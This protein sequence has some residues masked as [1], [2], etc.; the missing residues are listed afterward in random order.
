MV[1][2]SVRPEDGS[3]CP[4]DPK[5]F[6]A[7]LLGHREDIAETADSLDLSANRLLRACLVAG[8]GFRNAQSLQAFEEMSGLTVLPYDPFVNVEFRS[9]AEEVARAHLR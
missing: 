9:A 4:C 2:F 7:Y 5:R 8:V 3:H 1:A 6:A